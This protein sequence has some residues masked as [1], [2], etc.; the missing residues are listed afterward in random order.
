[1]DLETEDM[2]YDIFATYTS[3]GKFRGPN[4]SVEFIDENA[5]LLPEKKPYWQVILTIPRK[6]NLII[7]LYSKTFI[8]VQKNGMWLESP[9][10]S[11]EKLD[12]FI[13]IVAPNDL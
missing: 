1:M 9:L 2:A 12:R 10:K 7:R 11:Q 4:Q 6:L 8:L 5:G 3:S 13:E